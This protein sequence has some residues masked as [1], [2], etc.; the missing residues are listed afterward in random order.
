MQ[1]SI[2]GK[3]IFMPQKTFPAIFLQ[4]PQDGFQS[5]DVFKSP[6]NYKLSFFRFLIFLIFYS[7]HSDQ[8]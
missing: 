7:F 8:K 6:E 4:P 3:A 5:Q 2:L 1:G